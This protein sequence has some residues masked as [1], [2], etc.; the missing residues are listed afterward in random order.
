MIDDSV[1]GY[2]SMFEGIGEPLATF[3]DSVKVQSLY[4]AQLRA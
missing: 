3:D 2:D 1:G 4:T